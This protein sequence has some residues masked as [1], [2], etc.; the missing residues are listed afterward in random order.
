MR[1]ATLPPLELAILGRRW[2]QHR[3]STYVNV[4]IQ[5]AQ[6]LTAMLRE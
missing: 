3:R 1:A 5:S 2:Y 4:H 6:E